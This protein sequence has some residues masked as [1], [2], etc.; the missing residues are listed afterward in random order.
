MHYFP[1]EWAIASVEAATDVKV[2]DPF[3]DKFPGAP[4]FV[5]CSYIY[6]EV[7]HLFLDSPDINERI[8]RYFRACSFPKLSQLP[9]PENYTVYG[10]KD[11]LDAFQQIGVFSDPEAVD[12]ALEQMSAEYPYALVAA[13][14]FVVQR[15]RSAEL[16]EPAAAG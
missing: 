10:Y 13:G 7:E 12:E 16:T 6:S 2:V 11:G 3:H 4:D 5:Q 14:D 1:I 9:S 15:L 8:S